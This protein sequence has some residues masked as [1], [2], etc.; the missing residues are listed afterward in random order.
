MVDQDGFCTE[1]GEAV[2]STDKFCAGC[3]HNLGGVPAPSTTPPLAPRLPPP[4]K[5]QWGS[6]KLDKILLVGLL[7]VGSCN[8]AVLVNAPQWPES[9]EEHG[10]ET[11]RLFKGGSENNCSKYRK[12][13][14]LAGEVWT[15]PTIR[16][17]KTEFVTDCKENM[18]GDP[19]I[20]SL[21]EQ[22]SATPQ[23]AC[24]CISEFARDQ[25]TPNE[26]AEELEERPNNFA[27]ELG[28][29]VLACLTERAG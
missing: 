23:A 21:M 27:Y 24:V 25:W 16:Y 3:G 6:A 26:L 9:P 7:L 1:C 15:L 17:M 10:C 2:S 28:G 5:R 12:Q 19:V 4:P 22:F 8:V 18:L 14:G 11:V 13:A 29:G 20:R